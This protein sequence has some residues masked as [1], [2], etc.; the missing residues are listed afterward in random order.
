VLSW[1]HKTHLCADPAELR[2]DGRILRK[3]ITE[4]GMAE[5]EEKI[6]RKIVWQK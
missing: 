4:G 3:K 5:Q 2:R 1:G 6:I